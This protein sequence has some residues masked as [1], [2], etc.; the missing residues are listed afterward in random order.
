MKGRSPPGVGIWLGDIIRF[1][2]AERSSVCRSLIHICLSS[3]T[4]IEQSAKHLHRE[5]HD[6]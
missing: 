5:N 3:F 2:Y 4:D 6:Q 1:A